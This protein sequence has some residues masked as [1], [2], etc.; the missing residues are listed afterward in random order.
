[1][2]R[3][4]VRFLG[5]ELRLSQYRLKRQIRA[6]KEAFHNEQVA[7]AQVQRLTAKIARE[8]A[9]CPGLYH[10]D[11]NGRISWTDDANGG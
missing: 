11:D 7:R 9:H 3:K 4:S 2:A 10:R 1:M 6:R 8:F 5:R